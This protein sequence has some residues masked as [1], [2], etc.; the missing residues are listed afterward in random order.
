MNRKVNGVS[1]FLLT[2]AN[3][4]IYQYLDICN[5]FGCNAWQLFVIGG[6]SKTNIKQNKK[7]HRLVRKASIFYSKVCPSYYIQ[8]FL[9]GLI[10]FIQFVSSLENRTCQY[11]EYNAHLA[12]TGAIRCN[13]KESLY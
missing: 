2:F 4:E 11:Y 3:D 12:I 9:A 8:T 1:H 6:T 7:S 13:L 10:W 5:V